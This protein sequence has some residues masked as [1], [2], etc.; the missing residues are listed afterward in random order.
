MPVKTK[1]PAKTEAA[2][3]RQQIDAASAATGNGSGGVFENK[4]IIISLFS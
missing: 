4:K 2:I 3:C 1:A